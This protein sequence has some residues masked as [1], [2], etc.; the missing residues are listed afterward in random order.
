LEHLNLRPTLNEL[1]TGTILKEVEDEF[2]R[3]PRLRFHFP[4]FDDEEYAAVRLA[5]T[6]RLSKGEKAEI[7]AI[8]SVLLASVAENATA[9]TTKKRSP[10]S[11]TDLR[12]PL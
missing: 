4:W 10:P 3:N 2:H 5:K 12:T 8:T 9:Y 11:S 7:E 1:K 6:V